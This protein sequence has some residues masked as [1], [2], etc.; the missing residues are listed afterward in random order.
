MAD[1]PKTGRGTDYKPKLKPRTKVTKIKVEVKYK[2]E[3]KAVKDG[4]T[5]PKGKKLSSRYEESV[6]NLKE[7]LGV[8]ESFDV[9]CRELSYLGRNWAFFFMDGFTKDQVMVQIMRSF[10]LLKRDQV[11]PFNL[12]KF[13]RQHVNYIEVVAAETYHEIVDAVLAGQLAIIIDGQE[14]AI[15]LDTREYPARSPEEPDIER[16][17]RGSRDGFTETIVFNTALIRRRIRDPKLR[18]VMVQCGK[19]SKSDICIS[20]IEDIANKD[21][22][23]RLEKRVK[24]I[25]IDGLPMAEKSVE[26]FIDKTSWWNPFPRV[27]YTERPDVAAMHLLEGHVLIMV[28]TSPS[29]IIAPTTYFS[30]TQHAEEYRQNPL[31]GFY[32]RWV[33]FFAITA[34]LL[35]LPL[36]ILFSLEPSLLPPALKFV[37][38]KTVGKIPLFLQAIF[39][40]LGIDMLRMAAIH[41]PSPLATALGLVAA[42]MIG[43]TAVEVGLMSNEII[44]YLAFAAVGTF[45]TP[46]YELSQAN[47]LVR[48]FLVLMVGLLKLP[49]FLLGLAFVLI[50]LATT[51]SFGVP[52]LWPIIPFDFKALKSVLV[53]SPVPIKNSRPRFLDTQDGDRGL[54]KKK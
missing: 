30:H 10:E 21:L 34:S 28:D 24:D 40:E 13:I 18:M 17:T 20:Y 39:A 44:L 19:R 9:L 35:L 31:V 23:E 8:G 46:S 50:V 37:G 6:G 49:G 29:V 26:E 43:Q 27:R 52:Y 36:W 22:V 7:L 12:E 51:K 32:I 5:K 11:M 2:D 38:P 53:R 47:R 54:P 4:E 45:A 3:G 15:L 16:V 48:I 42:L 41:T 25:Q 1:A 14:K 33:R